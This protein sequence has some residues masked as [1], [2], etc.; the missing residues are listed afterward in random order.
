MCSLIRDEFLQ[1]LRKLSKDCNLKD[2][3][4][5]QYREELVRDSFINGLSLP[6][7][8][9]RLLEN[10]TLSLEQAY[11]QPIAHVATVT[12]LSASDDKTYSEEPEASALA[13]VHPKRN[14]YFCGGAPHNRLKCLARES[15]CYNCEIKGHFSRVCRFTKKPGKTSG[16]VATMYAPTL[17]ALGVTAAFPNSLSHAAL[18]VVIDGV[19]VT[20][21]I[22]SC[23]SDSFI[24]QQVANRLQLAIYPTTRNISMALTTLK[25]YVIGCCTT[26]ITLNDRTYSNV[27]LS[28]LKDLCSD[29]ILGHDFQNRH[30]LLTIEL[31]GSQ[32]DL[33]VSNSTSCALANLTPG[34]KPIATKSRRF[35][36]SDRTFIQEAITR[37]MKEDIIE[38]STSPWRAQVVVVKNPALPN[39]K[40]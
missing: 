5:D 15:V 34:S 23:S 37:L 4:A 12:P 28:V 16:N 26:D 25:T 24:H 18:P 9:Q 35:S 27:K 33:I 1:Q 19:T 8:R 30:K 31:H 7:I 2:V 32:S 11:V 29:I 22:D 6:L 3:T 13:A 39:K 38:H 21:L 17:C 14:C 10:T 20:A 36:L 40:R